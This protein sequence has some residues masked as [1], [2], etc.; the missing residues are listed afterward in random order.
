MLGDIFGRMAGLTCTE[1]VL[2]LFLL[3]RPI[4][5]GSTRLVDEGPLGV[6]TSDSRG[7]V[8]TALLVALGALDGVGVSF[9]AEMVD[10]W[11]SFS[12]EVSNGVNCGLVVTFPGWAE[13]T[14]SITCSTSPSAR[15]ACSF[16]AEDP[17]CP[18]FLPASLRIFIN[19]AGVAGSPLMATMGAD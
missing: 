6:V 2:F 12:F 9:W 10:V 11:S 17:G 18:R 14:S 19:E 1:L 15:D 8:N 16:K 5:F 13:A 3:S 7:L 4:D